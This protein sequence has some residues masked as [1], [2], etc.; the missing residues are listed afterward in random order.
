LRY[1]VAIDEVKDIV[2]AVKSFKDWFMRSITAEDWKDEKEWYTEQVDELKPVETVEDLFDFC[3]E[4]SWDLWSA[5]P[6]IA[7]HCFT[8]LKLEDIPPAPGFGP[9]A[10][11]LA[12]SENT[13][14]G[15]CCYLLEKYGLVHDTTVFDGFD[16]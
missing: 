4:A 9:P 11:Q 14:V 7:K 6:R 5:A 12:Q 1:Q 13:Q 15:I 2:A 3:R 16:T 10:N 8:N